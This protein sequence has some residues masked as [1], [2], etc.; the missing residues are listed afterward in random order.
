MPFLAWLLLHGQQAAEP[1]VNLALRRTADQLLR[2]SGDST[3]YIPPVEQAGAGIWRVKLSV[4]VAYEALPAI[5]QTSLDQYGIRTAYTVA[6]RRCSDEVIDLGY[7]KLDYEAGNAAP[8]GGRD[9]PARCYFL[10]VAFLSSRYPAGFLW[11]AGIF[12]LGFTGLMIRQQLSRRPAKPAI[13]GLAFGRFTLD[14]ANQT[15]IM[16]QEKQRLT[17][18]E[19]RLLELLIIHAGRVVAREEILR[20]VWQMETVYVGRNIDVLVSKLRKKLA[21]DPGVAIKVVQG[22]GYRLRQVV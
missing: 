6:L 20:A 7:H 8:C 1:A 15:L 11:A 10:E 5:L 21:G 3:S 9:N 2:Y 13:E 14:T 22:V 17:L 16:G 19:T 12:L 18:R 4:P